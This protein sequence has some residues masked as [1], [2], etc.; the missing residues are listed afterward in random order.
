MAATIV[1]AVFPAA[2]VATP[3]RRDFLLLE[4]FGRAQE[5]NGGANDGAAAGCPRPPWEP[6]LPCILQLRCIRSL[7]RGNIE[8]H[9]PFTR[10]E[11]GE[12]CESDWRHDPS[13]RAGP[14]PGTGPH[15]VP[16]SCSATARRR[17]PLAIT[18][19][20]KTICHS[21]LNLSLPYWKM[22]LAMMNSAV[23]KNPKP[24]KGGQRPLGILALV[25]P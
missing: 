15:C 5:A 19:V 23:P 18:C 4:L 25:P 17:H 1:A 20:L 13:P 3:L 11:A 14:L 2:G 10:A 6:E 9:R 12:G 21:K 24:P 16:A 8:D 22:T 7:A